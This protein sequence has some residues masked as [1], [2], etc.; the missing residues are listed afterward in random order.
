MF[1]LN[2]KI[3]Y[4]N[5][6]SLSTHIFS[7]ILFCPLIIFLSFSSFNYADAHFSHLA[8]I[9]A[10]GFGISEKYYVNEQTDPEEPIPNQLA[11]I[12]FSI[13]DRNGQ[14]VHNITA[15]VEVYAS[16]GTRLSV[17]PWT[18]LDIGDFSVPFIFPKSGMYQVVV[19]VLN[20]GASTSQI[21]NTIPPSRPLLNDNTG[22]SCERGV[23]NVA[24]S[25]TFGSI[26]LL[27]LY[28]AVFGAVTVIGSVLIWMY[29]SRRK[30]PLFSDTS[31]YDSLKYFVLIFALAASVVHLAVYP[32]HGALRVEYSIFLLSASGIQLAYGLMYI[33]LIFSDD[34]SVDN[35]LKKSDKLLVTK[36]YYK[37]SVILNLFGLIGSLV[38]ILLYVYAITFPPPLSPNSRPEDVD[39]SGIIDKALEVIMVIGILVL[40]RYE[41]RRYLYTFRTSK[42]K[43]F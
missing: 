27:L 4:K 32:E 15:L 39:L 28:V 30:N 18:K 12:Q 19:S 42:L 3:F 35:R 33:L 6:C 29:W 38:L 5:H 9:N 21:V 24:V 23:F 11:Q 17:F 13:Q 1:Y 22:C 43:K 41:R 8:H 10:G 20:D 31:K 40:M 34:N 37:K 26:F 16:N 2:L 14:D 7:L 25:N 36:Q